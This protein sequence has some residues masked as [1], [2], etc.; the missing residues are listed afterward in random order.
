ML[1]E[2]PEASNIWDERLCLPSDFD[3]S[4]RNRYGL[5]DVAKIEFTLR[6]GEAHDMLHSLRNAVR[7]SSQYSYEANRHGKRIDTS[8]RFGHA[9]QEARANKAFCVNEYRRVRDAMIR[10]GMSAVHDVFR[11]LKDKDTY[12]PKLDGATQFNTGK[13]VVGWIWT[14]STAKTGDA[15]SSGERET[16]G[17]H[18]NT[19]CT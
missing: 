7:G 17:T 5:N 13:E 2:L 4:E 15:R 8:T 10:L 9:A 12:R 1:N 18:Y 6:E 11:E 19:R 14:V 16:E 3:A